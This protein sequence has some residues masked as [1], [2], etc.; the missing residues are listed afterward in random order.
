MAGI[1]AGQILSHAAQIAAAK[2][3]VNEMSVRRVATQMKQDD[4][5]EDKRDIDPDQISWF[6]TPIK[7][8]RVSES[9]PMETTELVAKLLAESARSFKSEVAAAVRAE[10]SRNATPRN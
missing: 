10:A 8:L 1:G 9:V 4:R 3:A 6:R 5:E 2:G 7:C